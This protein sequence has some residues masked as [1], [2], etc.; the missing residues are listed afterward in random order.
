MLFIPQLEWA[1]LTELALYNPEMEFSA[2][3]TLRIEGDKLVLGQLIVPTQTAFETKVRYSRRDLNNMYQQAIAAGTDVSKIRCWIHG[4]GPY[5]TKLSQRDHESLGE[6]ADWFGDYAVALVVNSQLATR[7]VA[8]HKRLHPGAP[9]TEL[10]LHVVHESI[11]PQSVKDQ[12]A[13]WMK[14]VTYDEAESIILPE[15][16]AGGVLTV[17]GVEEQ[18]ALENRAV[19]AFSHYER[20]GWSALSVDEQADIVS[21]GIYD[22]S[23]FD[24]HGPDSDTDPAIMQWQT[25]GGVTQDG[26][27]YLPGVPS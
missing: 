7:A 23:M 9:H 2:F 4:H 13:E 27:H 11:R 15:A 10:N 21:S 19:K 6:F 22:T 16:E 12:V 1:Q 24:H 25:D 5:S 14:N 3:G 20:S 26:H 18:Q 17:E 8:A